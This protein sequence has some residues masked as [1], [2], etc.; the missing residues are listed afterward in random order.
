MNSSSK[1]DFKSPTHLRLRR[2]GFVDFEKLRV[3]SSEQGLTREFRYNLR[4]SSY[5]NATW[6]GVED[7]GIATTRALVNHGWKTS[8]FVDLS[9]DVWCALEN[10]STCMFFEENYKVRKGKEHDQLLPQT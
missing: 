3:F 4:R 9:V 10:I 6:S 1:V 8:E 5:V 7:E 2:P